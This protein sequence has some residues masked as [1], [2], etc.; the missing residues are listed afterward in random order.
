MASWS[1]HVNTKP[2]A[3]STWVVVAYTCS[4]LVAPRGESQIKAMAR[5]SEDE[6]TRGTEAKTVVKCCLK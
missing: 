3:Y 2:L 1:W 5:S 6:L 4:E